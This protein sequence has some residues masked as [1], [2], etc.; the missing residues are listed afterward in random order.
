[1]ICRRCKDIHAGNDLALRDGG[2]SLALGDCPHGGARHEWRPVNF[3]ADVPYIV[4]DGDYK[5]RK[6]TLA[7]AQS[8][9]REA[10]VMSVLSNVRI[11]RLL[12][13]VLE[14][15]I[16]HRK[17]PKIRIDIGDKLLA[18]ILHRPVPEGTDVRGMAFGVDYELLVTERTA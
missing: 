18:P 11:S 17:D 15:P 3:I 9:V 8:F 6:V 7:Q 14:H 13:A 4:T 2:I 12:S 1:M 5:A 16:I 10:Y